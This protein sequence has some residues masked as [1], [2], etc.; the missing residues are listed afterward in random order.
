MTETIPARTIIAA[1][2]YNMARSGHAPYLSSIAW[3][4]NFIEKEGIGTMG[5]DERLNVY[6]DPAAV[7]AWGVKETE[8]VIIHECHHV[9]RNHLQRMPSGA[10]ARAW[11]VAADAEINDDLRKEKIE[12]PAGG[13]Y[14]EA[15]GQKEWLTAETYYNGMPTHKVTILQPGQAGTGKGNEVTDPQCGT[16]AGNGDKEKEDGPAG[17][18]ELEKDILRRK[19]A[20]DVLASKERGEGTGGLDRW[21]EELLHPKVD[22]RKELTAVV[23]Q[24]IASCSGPD[25]YTYR[26]QNRRRHGQ[27]DL[28]FPA[29]T[30]PVI[31]TGIVIDTSGSMGTKELA[32]CLAEVRGVIDFAAGR[33]PTTILAVDW[34]VHSVKQV[35]DAKSIGTLPGGGGTDM[36]KGVD[37]CDKLNV[38]V[39]IVLTDGY[40]GWGPEPQRMKV[41]VGIIGNTN[42]DGPA[43]AKTI[44]IRD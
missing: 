40:T 32:E 39:C 23:K 33:V 14:P 5:T 15:L 36:S 30:S 28:I 18:G 35:W 20:E 44:Q 16:V 1:A 34:D 8:A 6:Y 42:Q 3:S 31:T 27:G 22:W 25:D 29:T 7:Q 9:I 21:A 13:V 24:A 2:R 19:V 38:D 43:Y 12:L 26:R 41:I 10:D 37:A 4:L 11:N 17:I